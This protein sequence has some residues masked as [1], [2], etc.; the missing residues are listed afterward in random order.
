M[1]GPLF[2][3]E[4]G[5]V[6]V[7][8]LDRHILAGRGERSSNPD[9]VVC[10]RHNRSKDAGQTGS[11]LRGWVESLDTSSLGANHIVFDIALC[12]ERRSYVDGGLQGLGCRLHDSCAEIS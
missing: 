8:R 5:R 10:L 4:A 2:G 7:G 1:M 11:L 6:L 3:P 12:M 9:G